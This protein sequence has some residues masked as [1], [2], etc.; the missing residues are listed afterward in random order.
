[1]IELTESFDETSYLSISEDESNA[2]QNYFGLS[3][4]LW[5]LAIVT[6]IAQFSVS[7]W[8]WQFGIF[9]AGI[10]EKWQLGI[11]FSFGTLL[12]IAGYLLS[13]T[14]SDM[15]GRRATMVFSFIPLS[16][17]LFLLYLFPVWPLFFPFY[18]LTM[19]GWSFVI[20]IAKTV[21]A[22]EIDRLRKDK[23]RVFGMVLMPAFL[24]D[25]LCPLLGAIMLN[26]G[27]E[28]RDF[29]LLGF[30]GGILAAIASFAVIQESLDDDT[31]EKARAGPKIAIRGLGTKFWT[32]T[33]GM[34][35]F[36]FFF[37]AALPFYGNLAVDDWGIDPATFGLT[38]SAFSIASSLLMYK[39][40]G[41]ADRNVKSALIIALV[42]NGVIM[43]I[44]GLGEGLVLMFALNIIWALAVAVWIGAERSL[45]IEDVS[46]EMKGRAMGTYSMFATSTSMFA[47]NFGALIWTSYGGL[48]IL[49][50]LCGILELVCI[51]FI[52]IILHLTR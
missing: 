43:L 33:F 6:G 28:Q 11:I 38:W 25:G 42:S 32:F 19:F 39:I 52:G 14:I 31:K 30:I 9:A 44:I 34:L 48:R 1:M 41:I 7:I 26:A 47:A 45:I 18:G 16:A 51:I 21:P 8:S 13:G 27:F 29:L 37:N 5:R 2:I 24:I 49:W 50:A 12:T 17:G 46:K 36:Y 23:V 20:I 15:F 3:P 4:R 22:D 35:G 40:T 10:V